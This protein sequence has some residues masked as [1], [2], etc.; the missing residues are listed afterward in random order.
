VGEYGSPLFAPWSLIVSYPEGYPERQEPYVL[1]D[2]TLANGV[3]ALSG[4]YSCLRQAMPCVSYFGGTE[5]AKVFLADLP[6][7]RF[8]Q[9]K[10]MGWVRIT[11]NE[12]QVV[13]VSW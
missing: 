13:R 5:R 12:A 4:A 7:T 10:V 11:L 8:S 2:G 1:K 3:F 6:G 9:T